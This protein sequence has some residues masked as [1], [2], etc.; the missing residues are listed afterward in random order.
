M[1][2]TYSIKA[3]FCVEFATIWFYLIGNIYK[4]KRRHVLEKKK[5]HKKIALGMINLG[6]R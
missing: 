5:F 3:A 2:S 1:H 6:I 4:G